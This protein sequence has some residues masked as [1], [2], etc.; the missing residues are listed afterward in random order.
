MFEVLIFVIAVLAFARAWINA[1]KLR[2][3][4]ITVDD[5]LDTLKS[6]AEAEFNERLDSMYRILTQPEDDA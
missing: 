5:M 3:L 1:Y 4:T 2:K 6:D